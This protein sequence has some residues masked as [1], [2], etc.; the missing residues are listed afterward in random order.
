MAKDYYST[1][2]ISKN[3]SNEEIKKAYKKMAKKYHPDISKESNASE[4]FK[5][6]NEAY[7]VLS[8]SSKKS[9][10][11][12]YGSAENSG[13][14]GFGGGGSQRSSG[15]G[16]FSSSDFGFDMDDIFESFGFGGG[17]SGRQSQRAEKEVNIYQNLTVSIEDVYFGK[18]IEIKVTKDEICSKCDGIGGSKNDVKTCST[19]NGSGVEDIIQKSFLGNIRSQRICSGCKGKGKIIHNPCASCGGEGVEKNKSTLSITIPKGIENGV[20]LRISKK[21][22]YDSYLKSYGDLYLKI[23]MTV[24][25]NIEVEGIDIYKNYDINFIQAILGDEI[26]LEHF[27][28]TLNVKI[29]KGCQ[30]D[31]ILRI[32]NY[33]M[34]SMSYGGQGDLYLKINILIPKKTSKEQEKLLISFGKTLKDKSL[35]GKIK[36]LFGK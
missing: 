11:D 22:H 5:E 2:G 17:S 20:T 16:G 26:E 12:N 36:S 9:N 25:E 29:P 28:K 13:F 32:K 27:D 7:S 21:G 35:F 33:G 1:L 4:K 19:C 31:T 24:P 10:F 8:D 18:E 14:G 15:G 3:A 34:P 23:N 6:V 30:V